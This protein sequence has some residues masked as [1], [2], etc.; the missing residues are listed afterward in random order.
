LM[1]STGQLPL[2]KSM[3]HYNAGKC[4]SMPALLSDAYECKSKIGRKGGK[5]YLDLASGCLA[6]VRK[7]T[8]ELL[9]AVGFHHEH[10]RPDRDDYVEVIGTLGG[11]RAPGGG[12]MG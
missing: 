1:G 6:S 9:H 7:V 5:Q 8:H 11:L 12:A 3:L 4:T 2:K 10:S